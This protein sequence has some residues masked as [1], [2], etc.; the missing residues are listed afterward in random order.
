MYFVKSLCSFFIYVEENN[1]NT[2]TIFPFHVNYVTP[3]FLFRRSFKKFFQ[4]CEIF[5]TALSIYKLL[6]LCY[7]VSTGLKSMLLIHI[8]K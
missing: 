8:T 3:A 5:L 1:I 6:V 4:I 7:Y 2:F